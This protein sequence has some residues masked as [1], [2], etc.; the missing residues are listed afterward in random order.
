MQVS[1]SVNPVD[2][3]QQL[4]TY[5]FMQ[6][7]FL[8]GFIVAVMCGVVGY[9]MVMR[10]QSFAGHTLSQI[11]FPGATGAVLVGI[12]PLIG[13]VTFC[14]AGALGIAA[15]AKHHTAGKRFETAAI[16]SVLAFALALGYL[17]FKLSHGISTTAISFLFGTFL[18]IP[19]I[20][21]L[22]LLAIAL[23]ALGSVTA[24]GRPLL[25]ESVDPDVAVARG[26]PVRLISTGFLLI[27]G[28]AAAACSLFTGTL[29]VFALLVAPAA[30][31]QRITPRPG[32][33]I[34]ISIAIAVT[35]TWTGLAL[36]YFSTY[37]IGFYV[38]TLAFAAYLMSRLPR[39]GRHLTARA[40]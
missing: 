9:F 16:G 5:H 10:G 30:T 26:V 21:V 15:L 40:A 13:L 7:A 8:A 34:G 38:T 2:D 39:L 6:N 25:F 14:G 36:A 31:A 20:Q 23:L 19:D 18:G 24:I 28:L 1:P 33:A 32:L 12:P 37:P 4:L 22:F 29:L 11:G 3:I 27:L 17:F 35:V